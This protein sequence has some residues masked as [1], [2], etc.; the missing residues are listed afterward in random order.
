MPDV[1]LQLI[2]ARI[3]DTLRVCFEL[4]EELALLRPVG[5]LETPERFG[6]E[7]LSGRTVHPAA[8]ELFDP[9]QLHLN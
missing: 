9:V 3:V 8:I 5:C 6:F 1:Q 4:H 7:E 2:V